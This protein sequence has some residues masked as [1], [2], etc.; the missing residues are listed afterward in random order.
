MKPLILFGTGEHAEVARFYFERDG[1]RRVEAVCLDTAYIREDRW[2]GLAV[3]PF[4]DVQN[5]F[6]P[7]T[8]D[9][10][11]A[12]GY[13]QINQLRRDKFLAAQSKGYQL[14]SY[15]SSRATIWSDATGDNCFILENNTI[16]PFV[17]IGHNVTMWSGNHIGHHCTI[18]D[19]CFLTSHVVVSGKTEVGEG[20]FIGVNATLRDHLRIGAY[21]VIG[22]GALI[23]RDTADHEVYSVRRTES[24]AIKSTD[25]KNL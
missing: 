8:H 12:V 17:R 16:Q 18:R 6:P 2:Q 25:L 21:C 13:S 19:H 15:I 3:L 1:G 24:S 10:F 5:A 9:M 7:A 23:M 20:T 14:A 11:I 4:E 22:A